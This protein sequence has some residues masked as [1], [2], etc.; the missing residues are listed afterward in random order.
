M[1]AFTPRQTTRNLDGRQTQVFLQTFGDRV[2]VLVTQLGKVG[3]LIQ[4]TL[5]ATAPLMSNTADSSQPNKHLLP[6]PSPAVQLTSLLGSS[7]SA[8]LQT[9]H[10]LYASQIATIIWTEESKAG[11]EGLR[12]GVVVGLALHKLG[13]NEETQGGQRGREVFEGVMSMLY[14]LLKSR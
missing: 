1:A 3:N 4:A 9:L 6:E 13:E 10:S 11:L 7:P 8:H 14:D 2:L 12:R 5:P